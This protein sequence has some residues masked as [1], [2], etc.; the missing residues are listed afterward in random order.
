MHMARIKKI[1]GKTSCILIMW[2][3]DGPLDDFKAQK[4]TIKPTIVHYR[5]PEFYYHTP[6]KSGD[7]T[8]E[9]S[10][11]NVHDGFMMCSVRL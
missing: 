11:Y 10:C 8:F 7:T 2:S 6:W 1:E 9:F 3:T 5:V 4:D